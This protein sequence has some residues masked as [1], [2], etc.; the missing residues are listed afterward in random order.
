MIKIKH[1]SKKSDDRENNHDTSY[2]FIDD[3]DSISI[4]LTSDLI[5][6]PSESKP[7]QQGSEYD[8]RK[9][10]KHLKRMVGH[11]K[12]KLGETRHKKENNQRIGERD[13]KGGHSVVEQRTLSVARTVY[14]LRRVR[15]VGVNT[16][17][18][19]HY[20]AHYLQVHPCLLVA[21]HVH[22]I[23]HSVAGDGCVYHIT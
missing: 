1:R 7:P 16:K 20:A 19:K 15:L 8:A 13:K 6:E 9:A 22:H 14:L 10:N 4:K 5:D 18:Q 21:Q 11:Y 23:A 3:K 12:G 2:H 17:C